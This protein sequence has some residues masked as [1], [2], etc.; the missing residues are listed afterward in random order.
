V[1]GTA[2]PID[3]D[4][5][6]PKER[7]I[8]ERYDGRYWKR[9]YVG[10]DSNLMGV[11]GSS[12]TD[13]FAVG[14][15]GLILHYDGRLWLPM[16][17]HTDKVLNGVW[18]SSANDVFAVGAKGTILHY[19]GSAWS[20]MESFTSGY[21]HSIWGSSGSDVYAVGHID[22]PRTVYN[23][24]PADTGVILHYDGTTWSEVVETERGLKGI[25][26]RSGDDVFA[27]GNG[28]LILHYDGSAW[29]PMNSGTAHSLTG[30]SGT[31]EHVYA[32]GTT[33]DDGIIMGYQP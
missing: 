30:I 6:I 33:G 18:G 21:L 14:S 4:F 22:Y 31:Q 28:G 25:W 2:F 20:S 32:V 19:N 9:M 8:V 23:G 16:S 27:V 17:S 7:G 10:Y 1:G 15:D 13:V 5:P 24:E 11:W 29:S 26:G 3:R 12:A